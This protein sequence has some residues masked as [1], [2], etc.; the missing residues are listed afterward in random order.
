M[1][2]MQTRGHL[3]MKR[4][5]IRLSYLKLRSDDE[6]TGF[7]DFLLR[8]LTPQ[9]RAVENFRPI[10]LFNTLQRDDGLAHKTTDFAVEKGLMNTVEVRPVRV[11]WEPHRPHGSVEAIGI[12]TYL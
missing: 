1:R 3:S 2:G 6:I 10:R 9:D 4:L 7:I 8:V 11:F 5:A 12:K